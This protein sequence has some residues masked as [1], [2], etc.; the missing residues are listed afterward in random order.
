L[1][2]ANSENVNQVRSFLILVFSPPFFLIMQQRDEMAET[3]MAR[4]EQSRAAHTAFVNLNE[5]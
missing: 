4:T 1:P 5:P 3:N 2:G